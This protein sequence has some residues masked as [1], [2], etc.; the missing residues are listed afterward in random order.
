[1]SYEV[2]VGDGL[3]GKSLIGVSS[4]KSSVWSAGETIQLPGFLTLS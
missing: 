4:V 3:C 1:M 2:L